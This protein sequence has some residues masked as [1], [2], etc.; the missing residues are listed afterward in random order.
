[1][2]PWRVHLSTFGTFGALI[3]FGIETLGNFC[4]LPLLLLTRSLLIIQKIYKTVLPHIRGNISFPEH[5]IRNL[6]SEIKINIP[7]DQWQNIFFH[8]RKRVIKNHLPTII[9]LLPNNFTIIINSKRHLT[10]FQSK[11]FFIDLPS[12]MLFYIR[13]VLGIRRLRD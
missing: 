2:Q 3:I 5:F 12:R 10:Y 13:S 1:M 8:I 6:R 7:N 11:Y 9:N 4:N